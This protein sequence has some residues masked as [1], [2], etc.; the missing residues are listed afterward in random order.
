MTNQP[1]P[2]RPTQAQVADNLAALLL[3]DVSQGRNVEAWK[4]RLLVMGAL[5][6][7]GNLV[8]LWNQ[9]ITERVQ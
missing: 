2:E 9:A 3:S 1:Q 4:T 8:R 7:R 5:I 6:P